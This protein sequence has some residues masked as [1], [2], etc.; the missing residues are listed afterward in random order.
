M[1]VLVSPKMKK[2]PIWSCKPCGFKHGTKQREV[3]T[4]HYGKCDVCGKNEFVTEPRDYGHFP[5][6]FKK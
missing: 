6:W 4:W 3:S 2:Y 1:S 5:N